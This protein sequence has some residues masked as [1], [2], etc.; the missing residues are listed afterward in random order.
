M[1]VHRTASGSKPK[2]QSFQ[3]SAGV[4][5]F[6]LLSPFVELLKR[7]RWVVQRQLSENI[8]E[9][10]LLECQEKCGYFWLSE[11]ELLSGTTKSENTLGFQ[12]YHLQN[13]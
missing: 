4:P 6:S 7:S 2:S 3:C 5:H 13:Q 10:L 8:T 9:V 1:K 12:V 11:M